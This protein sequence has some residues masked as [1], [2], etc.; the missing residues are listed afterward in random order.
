MGFYVN[1]KDH[2]IWLRVYHEL[3]TIHR[4]DAK[5]NKYKIQQT[6]S[7]YVPKYESIYV[8]LSQP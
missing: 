7:Q 5:L 4:L 6:S 3:W 8:E 2:L 1:L